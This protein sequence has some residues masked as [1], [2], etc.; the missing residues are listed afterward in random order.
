MSLQTPV[1]LI[2]F[3]R[4][5]LT[6]LIFEAIAREKPNTLIVIADG[7]RNNEELESCQNAREVT[8]EVN[9][10]CEVFRNYSDINLGC[11]K[12]VSSGLTWAF[13]L[14]EEAIILEDDC[15]P[16]NCF[17]TFCDRLLDYYRH[18][19]R[20]M[21]ISGSN[22]LENYKI[23]LQ[24]YLFSYY[25]S[26]WGWATWRRAWRKY[27]ENIR[28]WEDPQVKASLRNIFPNPQNF[29]ER[30]E[31]FDAV[32]AG[33]IDTWDYQWT[34]SRL[35]NCGLAITPKANLIS[36]IGF[37]ENATH[38]INL[39][40]SLANL[41]RHNLDFPLKHPLTL[42]PDSNYLIMVLNRNNLEGSLMKR[43]KGKLQ[44]SLSF[45]Y[46]ISIWD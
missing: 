6:K 37:G 26:V 12:R 18:D 9:W 7:P 5:S 43:I 40:S 19:A 23:D 1:V 31:K 36:N 33:K 44:K 38:T 15:L 21:M 4:P 24:S 16:N 28:L 41:P 20:V 13:S 22:L 46:E 32:Y 27:D 14:V 11:R 35:I 3:N 29:R 34:F 8:E 30:A 25:G 10:E 42:I 2:I 45:C 39:N 17:F